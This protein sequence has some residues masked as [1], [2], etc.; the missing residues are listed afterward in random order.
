VNNTVKLQAVLSLEEAKLDITITVGDCVDVTFKDDNGTM[1]H[2]KGKCL[3]LNEEEMEIPSISPIK[4]PNV[5]VKFKHIVSIEH[6]YAGALS[7]GISN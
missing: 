6:I 7:F 4:R 5:V 2:L 1:H 3:K